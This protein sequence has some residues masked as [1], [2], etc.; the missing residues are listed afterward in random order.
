MAWRESLE[1]EDDEEEGLVLKTFLT[2]ASQPPLA[3]PGFLPM[4]AMLC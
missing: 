1:G 4:Y 2:V 3:P